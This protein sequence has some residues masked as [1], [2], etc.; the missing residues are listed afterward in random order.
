MKLADLGEFGFI[1]RIKAGV[2]AGPGV[3][4][5]IGDDC[6]VLDL[7]PGHQLLTTT[8]ML[9]EEIHFRREWTDLADLGRKSVAVNVSDVA[10]MGGIPRHLYLSLG[11]PKT[12][13]LE[14]L[15]SFVRGFLEACRFYRVSLVG[16][17][18]C[19]SP[20]PLVISVTVEGSVP[21]GRYVSRGGAR[22]GDAIYAS[23]TL[24]DSAL[25]LHLL[26]AKETPHPFLLDRHV[27]PQARTRLG[28]ALGE[29]RLPSAMIDLSDGLLSDLGHILECSEAGALVE[30][31]LLPLSDPF[32]AALRDS[33]ELIRLALAGGEDYE[34]LFTVSPQ[35]ENELAPL[36]QR[37]GLPLTR[38]GIITE[39]GDG[40]TVRAGDG[41]IYRPAKGGFNHFS[42]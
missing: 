18:T 39:K 34:L 16:G 7:P 13:P 5:G 31:G 3:R 22:P 36:V 41:R 38:V 6:A 23:G 25:A 42:G 26:S 29:S 40:L 32:R 27:N 11:F 24:G 9:I 19:S 2:H 37:V 17:D 20:G 35:R 14:G 21:A 4:L 30:E 12:F 10:A 28:A 8:D 1:D 15:D 33:P